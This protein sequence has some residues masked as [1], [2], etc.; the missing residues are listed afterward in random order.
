MQLKGILC[1]KTMVSQ[2]FFVVVV[3]V[4]A[5]VAVVVPVEKS[6]C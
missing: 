4:A 6:G 3:V 2:I 5:V 1:T